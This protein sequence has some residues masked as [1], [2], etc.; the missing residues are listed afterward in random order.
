MPMKIAIGIATAGRREVMADTLGFLARQK[1]QPDALLICPARPED[2]DPASIAGL[3]CPVR[4]VNG[5]I[6]SSAQRNAIIEASDADVI[7]FFDDDFLPAENFLQQAE[8]LFAEHPDVVVATGQVLADGIGGAGL[9][10][11]EGLEVLARAR[12]EPAAPWL[13]PTYNGYGCN[14]AVRMAPV[15]Q[16]C[17]RFDERLPLYGWLEDVDF[18]RQ[19]AAHGEIVKCTWLEGVHLGTKRSG[20]SPGKRLGYSQV[21]NRIYIMR[22]GHMTPR[23]AFEGNF[24]NILANL[25]KSLRPE[26]WVDRRGRLAG[27][28]LAVWDWLRG[29]VDP[30]RILRF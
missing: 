5:P 11:A 28:V 13:S 12:P 9:S 16:H 6:G 15:R 30:E 22:K 20:R 7:V 26:P 25:V 1:R 24:R 3:P 23:Q 10:H 2:L 21:A 27:N 18:S 8:R 19:L 29:Q 14:M 4:I 17:I